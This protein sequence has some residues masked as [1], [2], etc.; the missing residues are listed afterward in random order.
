M[1]DDA[2]PNDE[3]R[4]NIVRWFYEQNRKALGMAGKKISEVQ[5][6]LRELHGYKK[7]IVNENL[8]Y[9]IERDW[10]TAEDVTKQVPTKSGMIR[11]NTTTFYKPSAKTI[12]QIEGGST[13]APRE[14]YGDIN[15][16][17]QNVVNFGDG[18]IVNV[19]YQ[20]AHQELRELRTAVADSSELTE[21][22]KLEVSVDLESI[23]D[24]LAKSQPN[25]T[26]VDVLW[27]RSVE[28]LQA[29]PGLV[30]VVEK[31]APYVAALAAAAG[32]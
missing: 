24:Q 4:R 23:M 14:R 18:N 16:S 6:G 10:I 19:N 29:A 5:K 31:C 3:I 22:S 12:E 15:I 11:P 20:D 27:K 9:L 13:F 1:P 26:V 17:G 32:S 2:N 28:A 21:S 7:Q 25:A 30:T 8:T